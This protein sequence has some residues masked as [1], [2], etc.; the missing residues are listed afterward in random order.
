MSLFLR[1]TYCSNEMSS[2][3]SNTSSKKMHV[4]CLYMYVYIC[5]CV[6]VYMYICMYVSVIYFQTI[7]QEIEC[8]I[9]GEGYKGVPFTIHSTFV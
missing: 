1:N 8:E 2:L 7:Q 4:L 3:L 9:I 5:T 6:Y